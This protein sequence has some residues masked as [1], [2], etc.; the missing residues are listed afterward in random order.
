MLGMKRI[1]GEALWNTGSELANMVTLGQIGSDNIEKF[2]KGAFDTVANIPGVKSGADT[3]MNVGRNLASRG[4]KNMFGSDFGLGGSNANSLTEMF[5]TSYGNAKG[6]YRKQ[7]ENTYKSTENYNGKRYEFMKELNS[8]KFTN[9]ALMNA[10]RKRSTFGSEYNLNIPAWATNM[11]GESVKKMKD[12][13]FGAE[14][15][16]LGTSTQMASSNTVSTTNN[17]TNIYNE[18]AV[19]KVNMIDHYGNLNRGFN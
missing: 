9:E 16:N 4:L 18:P 7:L 1:H 10:F 14:S 3:A 13:S 8:K 15:F 11:R 12:L 19:N 17:V 5:E 2:A 6:F